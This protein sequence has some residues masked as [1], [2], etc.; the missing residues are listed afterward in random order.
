MEDEEYDHICPY[1]CYEKEA[2]QH[3][4]NDA[5]GDEVKKGDYILIHNG[6]TIL[7]SNAIDYLVDILG[8]ER[9]VAGEN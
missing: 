1:G 9:K 4:G 5:C 6:E 3:E 7:E 8:A 2:D